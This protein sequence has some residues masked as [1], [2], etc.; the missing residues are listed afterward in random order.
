MWHF[1]PYYT[2]TAA[3]AWE[4]LFYGLSYRPG[5]YKPFPQQIITYIKYFIGLCLRY[6]QYMTFA[7]RGYIQK[8]KEVFIFSNFVTGYLT[9]YYPGKYTGHTK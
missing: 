5:K 8:S 6:H 9:H 4:R 2:D 1:K 7:H 3:V